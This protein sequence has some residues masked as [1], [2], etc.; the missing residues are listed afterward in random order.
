MIHKKILPRIMANNNSLK[1][2]PAANPPPAII[3]VTRKT[4]PVQTIVR[5]KQDF[6]APNGT[7]SLEYSLSMFVS[8]G[9]TNSNFS[10]LIHLY[11]FT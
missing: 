3:L 7:G 6:L 11:S 1:V 5:E 8:T 2:S 9:S 4:N 10:L